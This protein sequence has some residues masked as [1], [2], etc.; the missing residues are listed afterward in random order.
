MTT[1]FHSAPLWLD[2]GSVI[3]PGNFGRILS[4]YRVP[5]N[6]DQALML[7]REMVFENVRV[8]R[9]PTLP[10]RFSS[11][12]VFESLDDANFYRNAFTPWNA[13][14]EVRITDENQ[15]RHRGGFDLVTFPSLA[16]GQ[17]YELLPWALAN[18][19]TYWSGQNAQR[20]EILTKSPIS[21]VHMV[22]SGANGFHP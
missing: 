22:Q 18:A 19:E 5:I 3:R 4:N 7:S 10:S 2:P 6:A 17:H 13:I 20:A 12:F 16:E 11:C 14:Y 1:Y 15:P 9:Y 8:T 21:I